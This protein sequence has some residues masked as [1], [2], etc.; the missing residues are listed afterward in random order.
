MPE[1]RH[2]LVQR[3]RLAHSFL[4]GSQITAEKIGTAERIQ[5]FGQSGGLVGA[6]LAVGAKRFQT[7]TLG[8]GVIPFLHLHVGEVIERFRTEDRLWRKITACDEHRL[9]EYYRRLL[10]ISG[11]I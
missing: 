5:R 1:A 2:L 10:I 4:R 8:L 11:Q 3:Q 9:L 6:S 7:E